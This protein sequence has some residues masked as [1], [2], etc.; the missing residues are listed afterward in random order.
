MDVNDEE[1]SSGEETRSGELDRFDVLKYSDGTHRAVPAGDGHHVVAAH[2][3][4]V[5]R[6]KLV[7]SLAVALL[8]SGAGVVLGV[9]YSDHLWTLAGGGL[10]IGGMAGV[11]SYKRRDQDGLV[12][13]VVATDVSARVVRDYVDDF[14]PD[15]V[16]SPFE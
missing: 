3:S 16:L 2:E 14:D 5:R 4:E 8:L 6:R 7:R 13:A 1:H 9:G 11:I 15:E 12:P 10:A